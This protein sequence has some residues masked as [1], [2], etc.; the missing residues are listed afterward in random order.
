MNNPTGQSDD[1][2]QLVTN[3][4]GYI[5]QFMNSTAPTPTPDSSS[6]QPVYQNSAQPQQAPVGTA[7]VSAVASVVDDQANTNMGA[8]TPSSLP[9]LP[10][11]TLYSQPAP[12]VESVMQP[13]QAQ[14]VDYV[15]PSASPSSPM[16]SQMQTPPTTPTLT[17][18]LSLDPMQTIEPVQN[19]VPTAVTDQN[20]SADTQGMYSSNP[21]QPASATTTSTYVQSTPVTAPSA[22]APS[23]PAATPFDPTQTMSPGMQPTPAQ[24][25][26]SVSQ[27][28]PMQT[29]DPTTSVTS[30]VSTQPTS[31]VG[32]PIQAE[33]A[34]SANPADQIAS[35]AMPVQPVE[36]PVETVAASPE[37]NEKNA[38]I[39]T[40]QVAINEDYAESFNP[41][42]QLPQ[43][44][45]QQS[46][47]PVE[48]RGIDFSR[49]ATI[50][51]VNHDFSDSP[52]IS[53][54]N[55]TSTGV[56]PAFD[57][58]NDGMLPVVSDDDD[59]FEDD[60]QN[61][62]MPTP[63]GFSDFDPNEQ[64]TIQSDLG[65]FESKSLEE[66]ADNIDVDFSEKVP[67]QTQNT[68]SVSVLTQDP[69]DQTPQAMQNFQSQGN[70]YSQNSQVIYNN[71]IEPV[72]Q[73]EPAAQ[74]YTQNQPQY[75][76]SEPQYIQSQQ[77]Q[78]EP[79][80]VQEASPIQV[81]AEL[82]PAARLNQLLEAEEAAEKVII[83]KQ[84][85]MIKQ[86]SQ[87]QTVQANKESIFKQL[88]PDVSLQG[89]IRN[90]MAVKK[91]SSRYFL[92]ISLVIII[93]VIGFLLVLLGLTLL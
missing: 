13:P 29:V 32:T 93:S 58:T 77:Q 88:D 26:Y 33:Q 28:G 45:Q 59:L 6:Q 2:Q 48:P 41:N 73:V 74:N 23:A 14:T 76:Q 17:T 75:I 60:D 80:Y 83:Q 46:A 53:G 43:N 1:L 21:A 12:V 64:V 67:T 65:G 70:G 22:Y 42:F 44:Y 87:P 18:P 19:L 63:Y 34:F 81:N 79:V 7:P 20:Y 31:F 35:Q 89:D 39:G 92:I 86:A 4:N 27:P 91:P 78:I 82:S 30:S 84:D 25:I 3:Q 69:T 47:R 37:D 85:Q 16:S 10:D 52:Q 40:H 36:Q 51:T 50:T 68:Q 72:N 8:A 66:V 61:D 15:S 24:P 49:P 62:L 38:L 9:P 11:D 71:V 5:N 57:D 56:L 54:N 55:F 90:G